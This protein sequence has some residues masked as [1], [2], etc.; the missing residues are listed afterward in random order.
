ME[1]LD[2]GLVAVKVTN[3]VFL[4][5]R[6]LG[7]DPTGIGFNIYRGTTKVN[8]SVITGATN[9]TDAA[10]TTSSTYTVRPVI[11]NV[12][13][14]IGGSAT[15]WAN[16]Y[17]TINMNLPAGGTGPD[18]V[19]YTYTPNDCSV[20]DVDGDGQWEVIVKWDPS[21]AKDNSQ[22]GN[23][24]NVYLDCYEMDGTRRWRI[25]L[26]K[27]IRAGAHYTQFL[28]GDYDGNGKAEMACKTAPGTKDGTGAFLSK[29]PAANDND[30]ADYRNSSGYI[31]TG[32][33]YYTIFEGLTGKE[34]ATVSYVPVRGTVSSWGD[35]YGN[36]V[37]RFLATNAYL[38]GKKPSMVIDRGY[39][40]RMSVTAW[41]WNGTT[42]SQRWNYDAPNSGSGG[43]GQ[44]NHNLSAGDVDGDGF[45]EIIHGSCAIDHNG[46][47]LY[48]TGLGHGDAIHFGDLN[49]N[50]A[51]LEVWEVHEET[52]VAYAYELHDAKTGQIIWGTNY[53]VDNGRGMAGDIDANSPG[54]EM[55]SSAGTGIYS[56]TGTQLST[57]KPSI[58]FRVYWDG[59]LQ[60]E[61]LDGTKLDK[62]TGN[63]T[64]RLY[65]FYNFANAKEVNGT[66]ANPC[67]SADILGDWRE[68]VIY[69]NSVTPSQLL[70][71]TTVT[72]TTHRLYTLMHDPVYRNAISWQNTAYN[73]PPHLGFFLG[74]GVENAPKPNIVLVGSTTTTKD[75]NG[76]T[77][78]SAYL[79]QCNVCVGGTTGK[80]ACT[81]DCNGV[82]GG[83]AT[84]DACGICVGGNTG[85]TACTASIQAESA[86]SYSGTI[87]ANNT[88]F[89]GTGFVNFTNATGSSMRIVFSSTQNAT[90]G[91]GIRYANGG[92]T[93]RTMTLSVNG[94]NQTINFE[95]SGSWTTWII[96]TAQCVLK[97]GANEIILTSTT[98][99]GGPNLDLFSFAVNTVTLGSCTGDC[100]GVAGG[101]AYLDN[102][103]VCVGGNTGKTACVQ[104][105]NGTWGGIAYRDNC[106]I[107]VGGTT[108]KTACVPDCNG[109]LGGTAY[110]DGCNTCVGGNT[111]KT[112]CTTDCNGVL[113]GTA[114]LD[115]CNI[116]VGGNTGKTACV[117]DCNGQWGG[118]AIFDVCGICYGGTTGKTPCSIDCHSDLGGTA[119]I[120]NCNNCVG[121]NTGSTACVMDCNG[122]WGGSAYLDNC[123]VCVGG[124]TGKIACTGFQAENACSFLGVYE[125]IHDGYIGDN[126]INTNNVVGAYITFVLFA[127]SPK[128]IDL[129]IRYAN[130][131]TDQR[132]CNVLVND[133]NVLSGLNFPTTSAWASWDTITAN[134]PLSKGYNT[135]SLTATSATGTANLDEFW[136]N[137]NG[138][139][140]AACVS[141]QLDLYT[142]WNLISTNLYMQD[143]SLTTVFT[144]MEVL[145][146]KTLSQYWRPTQNAY[147]NTLQSIETGKGFLVYMNADAILT[148]RGVEF[149]NPQSFQNLQLSK[150]KKGWNLLGCPYQTTTTIEQSLGGNSETVETIK[151]SQGQWQ[152]SGTSNTLQNLEPGKGY[153]IKI[154]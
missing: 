149:V 105:C 71:F 1:N 137:A 16:Q 43:Y 32:E 117:Q 24:G 86:C 69:F 123:S 120:D 70:I 89:M 147:F 61:L 72:P 2:R 97:T 139:T 20:G 38:D 119:Y 35:N 112:P 136:Y 50:R 34:L 114:Y 143:S 66:K 83:T 8:T 14:E 23:T 36:R 44:G 56:C 59:D 146:V 51:G 60:D 140:F 154:K 88:G 68:E 148:L 13:Q 3:G 104:D 106:N 115:N 45:D 98:T 84:T 96:T 4:S 78:G 26:G 67:L 46:T 62:W 129:S 80:I 15:V 113:G 91:V 73:Q 150:M 5:W 141:Q 33:E 11:N 118:T 131:A 42:L 41:D 122:Q 79:D 95:P 151:N 126:Y 18:G 77:G 144:G 28:V 49:P 29:G 138:V 27:N 22:S 93:N 127:D 102:C 132:P 21:N 142:G 10:G 153:Y 99:D 130:G 124:N 17:L 55:W 110:I 145:E 63:G 111:G 101:S 85:K 75:C 74:N 6:V 54:Y 82:W 57:S 109:V 31:L 107:C 65:T 7:T 103:N 94:A 125:N 134:I 12:E 121:G 108:G 19:A 53:D 48:R 37:D 40:T 90:V 52:G 133:V 25:D 39:Y 128:N 64:T 47:L 81:Q 92:T 152:P 9:L 87:D 30:N 76:V 100:N 135:I 58:N 116:C